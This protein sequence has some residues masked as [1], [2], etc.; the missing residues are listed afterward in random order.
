MTTIALKSMTVRMLTLLA[1][2]ATSP[3]GGSLLLKVAEENLALIRE[4][5]PEKATEAEGWLAVIKNG[6]S[7]SIDVAEALDKMLSAS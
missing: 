7:Q 2:Q 6:N 4:R 3:E 5:I 1:A